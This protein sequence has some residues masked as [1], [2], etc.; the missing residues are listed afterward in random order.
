MRRS[1]SR[2]AV[3]GIVAAGLVTVDL[4]VAP[5]SA[6][7]AASGNDFKPGNII[8]DTVFFNTSTMSVS[9]VC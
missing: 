4:A 8:S 2:I 3:I 1:M 5:P 7:E 6:A 9:R